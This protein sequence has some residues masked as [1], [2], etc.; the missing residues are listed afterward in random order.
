MWSSNVQLIHRAE[1]HRKQEAVQ[2]TK[3]GAGLD[4]RRQDNNWVWIACRPENRLAG[5]G[6]VCGDSL[7]TGPIWDA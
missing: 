1:L 2:A 7:P 4:S 3:R 6:A 5:P